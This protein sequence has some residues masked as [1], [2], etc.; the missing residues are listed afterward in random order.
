MNRIYVVRQLDAPDSVPSASSTR[1]YLLC[2]DVEF[3]FA[4]RHSG[5]PVRLTKADIFRRFRI[6]RIRCSSTNEEIEL[7]N[8]F[9]TFYRRHCEIEARE[10]NRDKRKTPARNERSEELESIDVVVCM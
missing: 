10:E 9:S 5:Q 3:D 7:P 4:S 8:Q 6:I 2:V 1:N